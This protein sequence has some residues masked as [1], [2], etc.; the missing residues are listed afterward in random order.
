M[1]TVFQSADGPR[2]GVVPRRQVVQLLVP[3]HRPAGF[4]HQFQS[5]NAK[6]VFKSVQKILQDH[7]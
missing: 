1:S 4:D 2:E 6:I 7:F 5:G 3:L